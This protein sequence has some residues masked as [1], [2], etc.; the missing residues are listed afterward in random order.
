L[1]EYLKRTNEIS[2]LDTIVIGVISAVIG[3]ILV[4]II[5]NLSKKIITL[6]TSVIRVVFR[7]PIEKLAYN[8]RIVRKKPNLNDVIHITEKIVELSA[9][10]LEL[11]A[12]KKFN[13]SFTTMEE[14]N[15]RNELLGKIKP[16]INHSLINPLRK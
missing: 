14:Y 15:K 1:I 3:A 13:K 16:E 9:N 2:I 4:L 6:I 7:T 12:Y 5:V 11:R 8:Y 10:K